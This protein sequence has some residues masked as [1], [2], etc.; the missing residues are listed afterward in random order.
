MKNINTAIAG[1]GKGARIYNAPI[2]ASVEGFEVKKILSSTPENIAAAKEDFPHA[3]VVAKYDEILK[4]PEV[5]LVIITTPNHLHASF[6]KKAI[7]AGK[8]VVVEKPFTPTS[9]E[10]DELIEL[11]KKKGVLLT[12]NHNRRLDSDFLTVKK[13]LEQKKLGKVVQYEAHFD[14]FRNEVTKNWKE[15]KDNEGNGILYDLG[16]HLIDQA[17]HLFGTPNEVFADIRIQRKE[18]EVPDNFELLLYYKNLKVSLNAGMLVKEKGPTYS[19]HGTKGSFIKY[20]D[21]PQEEMLK[22]GLKPNGH[23]GWGIEADEI[24]GKY[25][26]LEESGIIESEQ[27]DYRN[28]YKN[29]YE[30]LSGN[31]EL[32]VKP[33]EAR[34]V[35]KVIELALQSNSEKRRVDFI[36]N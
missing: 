2:I 8:H 15:D 13:L 12:V 32:H 23:W 5:E 31:E 16:S 25:N 29:L 36:Q 24:W 10:A 6:A 20:G 9:R 1:Y 35:I 19:I 11:A 21:D 26:G 33:E 22:L 18:A 3:E 30:A 27:G 28:F 14:R 17:L 34:D 7:K 4:D